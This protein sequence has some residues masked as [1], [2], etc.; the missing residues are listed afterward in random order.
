MLWQIRG[1]NMKNTKRWMACMLAVVLLV[2]SSACG[3]KDKDKTEPTKNADTTIGAT[4][5]A[6][7]SASTDGNTAGGRFN[8]PKYSSDYESEIKYKRIYTEDF[9]DEEHGFYSRGEETTA[10]T[11]D[12]TY[13]NS[14]FSLHS[15]GRA[16]NWNGPKINLSEDLQPGK[17]YQVSAYVML[18]EAAE[19]AVKIDCK[20]EQNG[21]N[22]IDVGSIECEPGVWTPIVGTVMIGNDTTK[23]E[24][25][26]ETDYNNMYEEALCDLYVDNV[27]LFELATESKV[28]L[29]DS[30][31]K[32]Y[33]NYF[34]LGVAVSALELEDPTR[35]AIIQK[36]FNSITM[37]NEMK[38]EN[39]L[40]RS[41]SASD[42]EKYNTEPAI[43]FENIDEALTFAKENNMAMRGHTL[44]WHSQTPDWFFKEGYSN[45]AD[46]PNVSS[47]VMLARMESYIK[48]V[49]EYCAKNYPG[50]VVCWDVVNEAIN[51]PDK[52][53]G[54]LRDSLWYQV[55]GPDFIEKAFEYARKYAEPGTKL[56]YNDYNCFEKVK[57]NAIYNLCDKLNQ[58]GI[59]DGIGVQS[60]LKVNSPS[61]GDYENCI[62]TLGKLGLE[63]NVTELDIDQ[64]LNTEE[65]QMEMARKYR[66]I[67]NMYANVMD[68][69]QANITNVTIWG[70]SDENSWLNDG[71]LKYPLLFDE[72]LQP[73]PAFWG[74]AQDESISLFAN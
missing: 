23:A 70:L 74:V 69:K 56:F 38:P 72:Y 5:D 67:F 6:N 18:A 26:F 41:V 12:T 71:V 25:Y 24:L 21:S 39:L 32:T 44:V 13:N 33:E 10:L 58:K 61:M 31:H 16:K 20:V 37:G 8:G 47:E 51:T 43:N 65:G 66:R 60:H 53:D 46:A 52:I 9:E 42:I 68:A 11:A 4:D 19:F 73:K 50:I 54:G 1:S 49:L 40:N 35:V 14:K 45:T 62:V 17:R 63:I 36:H 7:T 2:S 28:P 55:A 30:L 48:Q 15:S 34:K 3:K 29:I 27:E 22:Y 57:L 64:T 59:I